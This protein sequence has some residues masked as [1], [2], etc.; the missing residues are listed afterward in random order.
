MIL[1]CKKIGVGWLDPNDS[2]GLVDSIQIDVAELGVS[3]NEM[4]V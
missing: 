2:P 1:G 4:A 3:R